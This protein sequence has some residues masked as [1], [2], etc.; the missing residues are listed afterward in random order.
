[1]SAQSCGAFKIKSLVPKGIGAEMFVAVLFLEAKRV[2]TTYTCITREK[3]EQI[4][5]IHTILCSNKK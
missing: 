4:Q 5:Y 1:M 2:E 3:V